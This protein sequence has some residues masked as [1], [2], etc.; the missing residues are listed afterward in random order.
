M[1]C[2]LADMIYVLYLCV[3]PEPQQ[4]QTDAGTRW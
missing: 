1:D 4:G 3:C 2:E